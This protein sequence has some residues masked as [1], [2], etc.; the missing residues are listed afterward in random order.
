MTILTAIV[1]G[2]RPVAWRPGR[3]SSTHIS[4]ECGS[5]DGRPRRLGMQSVAAGVVEGCASRA[6][7]DEAMALCNGR[8]AS[9]RSERARLE[10]S[11]LQSESA[12]REA[13]E[14]RADVL[15]SLARRNGELYAGIEDRQARK[16][17]L[18]AAVTAHRATWDAV[19][20]RRR[21]Q[22]ERALASI[23][24]DRAFEE[25]KYR[26]S[27]EKNRHRAA[28]MVSLSTVSALVDDIEVRYLL[29]VVTYRSIV[30]LL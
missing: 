12:C 7:C 28:L 6:E 13:R 10:A 29:S 2:N 30:I 24:S 26:A 19:W 23:R 4:R 20:E 1:F 8:L 15:H 9:A 16:R 5:R 21:A 3:E 14:R 27:A 22:Y 25:S 11:A 18:F 17:Q